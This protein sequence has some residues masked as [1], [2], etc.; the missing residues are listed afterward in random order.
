MDLYYV[1]YIGND[2]FLGEDMI[3]CD[4]E[5]AARYKKPDNLDFE[6]AQSRY[7]DVRWVGPCR[8]GEHP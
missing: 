2:K 6:F 7:P 4:Y 3:A 1:L 5:E 8:E